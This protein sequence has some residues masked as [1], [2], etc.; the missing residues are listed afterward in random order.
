MQSDQNMRHI[1]AAY[2]QLLTQGQIES[3]QTPES[4]T[5]MVLDQCGIDTDGEL[6]WDS[7]TDPVV[8]VG[9]FNSRYRPVDRRVLLSVADALTTA[10]LPF[11]FVSTQA[12][13]AGVDISFRSVYR[14]IAPLDSIVQSAGRCNRSFE[15]GS[16]AGTVTI[17]TLAA[18]DAS[19][20]SGQQSMC[21]AE[22]VYARDI[23]DHLNIIA[24]T[25]ASITSDPSISMPTSRSASTSIPDVKMATDGVTRY[26][27]RL[28]E[29]SVATPEIRHEIDDCLAGCLRS[30][31][32]I[33][34]YETVDIL[35]GVTD[36]DCQRIE[37]IRGAYHGGDH[38]RAYDLLSECAD[39]RVSVP[40]H[41]NEQRLRS[42][43]RV[44]QQTH[45]TEDGIQVLAFTGSHPIGEYELASG[46]FSTS[47]DCVTDRFTI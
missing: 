6:S 8:L 2:Q 10:G 32:L 43:P 7:D 1:G 30:R 38:Q 4:I 33:Q 5:D 31:S 17:W 19:S 16:R 34:D 35:I 40:V 45:D 29:K 46:G 24:E 44:D 41:G 13:E 36:S 27:D 21:P 25:L 3:E 14:D 18:P 39:L 28:A 9:T 37:A 26:F 12:I 47:D 22:L 20:T 23:D 42:I 11:V 15:W